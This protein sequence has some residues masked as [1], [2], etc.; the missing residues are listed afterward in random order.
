MALHAS[1]YLCL[2]EPSPG[3]RAWGMC[4]PFTFFMQ[5][6]VAVHLSLSLGPVATVGPETCFSH[7]HYCCTW[8]RTEKLGGVDEGE[9]GGLR[10]CIG[11]MVLTLRMSQGAFGKNC[12]PSLQG[13]EVGDIKESIEG[14][15]RGHLCFV[16]RASPKEGQVGFTFDSQCCR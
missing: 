9:E 1:S 4:A 5:F 3:F 16:L 12:S 8:G 15:Q 6:P 14:S 13:S 2:V 7:A 11:K 10:G